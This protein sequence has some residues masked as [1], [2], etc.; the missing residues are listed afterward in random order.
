MTS[1]NRNLTQARLKQLLRYDHLTGEFVWRVRRSNVSSGT[2]AGGS[3]RHPRGYVLIGIH[4]TKY[5]A[6]RLAWLYVHGRWPSDELDHIDGDTSNNRLSNL[7]ECNRTLNSQN[8][9]RDV[10]RTSKHPGVH[11]DAAKGRWSARIRVGDGRRIFLG[12]FDDEREAADAYLRARAEHH[13][14]ATGRT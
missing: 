14:Y 10:G 2:V 11:W 9:V 1:D 13:P 4:G 3:Y 12:R 7:R 5:L 8:T 6:H